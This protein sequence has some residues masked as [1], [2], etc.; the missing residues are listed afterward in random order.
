[1][2]EKDQKNV[3]NL[4]PIMKMLGSKGAV[5]ILQITSKGKAD[6]RDLQQF[7]NTHTLNTRIGEFLQYN[8][9][10]HHVVREDIR[11]E[12]YEITEK[13]EK[14]VKILDELATVVGS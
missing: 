9:I 4:E 1:M 8:L 2:N 10:E 7:V 5:E 14:V 6:Y 3:K 11:K 13:G 12:W